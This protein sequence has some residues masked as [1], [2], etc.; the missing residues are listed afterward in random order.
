MVQNYVLEPQ[1]NVEIKGIQIN[2]THHSADIPIF[3]KV[4]WEPSVAKMCSVVFQLQASSSLALIAKRVQSTQCEG[5]WC[6]YT[7]VMREALGEG[8]LAPFKA[9]I[10]NI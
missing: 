10:Y 8:I 5:R 3:E 4:L 2:K 7:Y 9:L 6:V 1:I